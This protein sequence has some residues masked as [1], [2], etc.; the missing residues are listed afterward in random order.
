MISASVTA[1]TAAIEE[2]ERWCSRAAYVVDSC[3]SRL[4]GDHDEVL[5]ARRPLAN[6]HA[7]ARV[8]ERAI[9]SGCLDLAAGPRR[10]ATQ[11]T[12]VALSL[13]VDVE[14]AALGNGRVSMVMPGYFTSSR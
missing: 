8:R 6:A 13:E 5:E 14:P 12:G 11:V 3:A 9:V 4:P 10:P 1:G 2:R 7:D